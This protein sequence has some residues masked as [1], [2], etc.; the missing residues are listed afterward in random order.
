VPDD[1]LV[2]QLEKFIEADQ[3]SAADRMFRAVVEERLAQ[4]ERRFDRLEALIIRV[5]TRQDLVLVGI[6]MMFGAQVV[7][8]F[9][10]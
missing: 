6:V 5:Q 8:G 1:E 2:Q 9:L 3:G 7:A 10:R 4:G